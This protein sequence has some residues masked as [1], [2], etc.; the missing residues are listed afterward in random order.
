MLPIPDFVWRDVVA[1]ALFLWLL[2]RYPWL[3]LAATLV[4]SGLMAL[5]L[6]P[7]EL[8]PVLLSLGLIGTGLGVLAHYTQQRQA[9]RRRQARAPRTYT[10]PHDEFRT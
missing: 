9:M 1:P 7:A 8:Y 3:T 10:R 5:L 6:L 4:V 2:C